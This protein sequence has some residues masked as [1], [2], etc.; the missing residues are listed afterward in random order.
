[1]NLDIEIETIEMLIESNIKSLIIECDII[2]DALDNL[3]TRHLL[4]RLAVKRRIL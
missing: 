1:M 2:V 4:N 3:E